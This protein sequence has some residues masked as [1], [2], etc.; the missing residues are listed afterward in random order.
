VL[1]CHCRLEDPACGLGF[2][3][4]NNW[5]TGFN[6]PFGVCYI[7]TAPQSLVM[8]QGYSIDPETCQPIE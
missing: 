3:V 5:C 8:C 1:F 7:D 4:G 2:C 6:C